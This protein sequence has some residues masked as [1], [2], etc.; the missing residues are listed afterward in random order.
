MIIVKWD[1]SKR[2]HCG[3]LTTAAGSIWREVNDGNVEGSYTSVE[4]PEQ[5][6]LPTTTGW[7]E[8]WIGFT[9]TDPLYVTYYNHT[10]TLYRVEPYQGYY[11]GGTVVTWQS[12]E[13]YGITDQYVVIGFQINGDDSIGGW[14]GSVPGRAVID[15]N[16]TALDTVSMVSETARKKIKTD[17]TSQAWS[18]DSGSL[19]LSWTPSV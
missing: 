6:S 8:E 14:V 15:N 16:S 18:G 9:H 4:N 12:T 3:P 7:V 10:Y 17:P 11:T 1:S 13:K 2:Y 5:Q 19:V